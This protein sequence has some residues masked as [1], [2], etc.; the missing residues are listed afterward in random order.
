MKRYIAVPKNKDK[1][2]MFFSSEKE[3]REFFK[4]SLNKLNTFLE[5]GIPVF[6]GGEAYYLD[7]DLDQ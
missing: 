7:E 3:V 4:L 6:L 2:P 1:E 5:E